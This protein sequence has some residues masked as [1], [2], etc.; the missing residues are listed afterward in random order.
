MFD[1]ARFLRLARAQWAEQWRGWAWF[2]GVCVIL[3]FVALLLMVSGSHGFLE[4][5]LDAQRMLYFVG[6]FLT[7]PVFA[8]RYF[9]ALAQRESAGVLLMRPASSFEK[10]LLALLV[11]LVAYPLAYSLAFQV[12]N[13]PSALYALGLKTAAA[14]LDPNDPGATWWSLQEYGVLWPWT[15]F[16]ERGTFAT[17]GLWL[18]IFTGFAVLGSLYFRALPFLKTLVVGFVVFLLLVLVVELLDGRPE[19]FFTWWIAED[20]PAGWRAI[21]LPAAWLLV[22]G[23]LWLGALFA[24]RER[25]VS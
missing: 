7:G 1:P 11:V 16:A 14:P 6:L 13:L 3:H 17:T 19:Q 5:H 10:W 23:L 15:A 25:Q 4:L 12:L 20:P 24:L 8:G 21:F 22:P 18:A 2:L 9:Q